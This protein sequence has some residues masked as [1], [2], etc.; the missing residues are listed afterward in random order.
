MKETDPN[1]N[2]GLEWLHCVGVL[3][4]WMLPDGL[5]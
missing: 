2:G 4:Q 3:M 5:G 1:V